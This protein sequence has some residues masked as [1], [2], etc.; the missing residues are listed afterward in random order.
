MKTLKSYRYHKNYQN[1]FLSIP[2]FLPQLR[3]PKNLT[4]Q[5][6]FCKTDKTHAELNE[7]SS[8]I[9]N[10][11]LEGH[12]PT[13]FQ[14]TDCLCFSLRRD[15]FLSFPRSFPNLDLLLL[16]FDICN[17]LNKPRQ[18]VVKKKKKGKEMVFNRNCME[19]Q[20]ISLGSR[21]HQ[22][23]PEDDSE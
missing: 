1:N 8:S 5:A 15:Y 12:V 17:T 21:S 6:N 9:H 16:R 18:R 3:L 2:F 7:S 14:A 19:A 20:I 23:C 13:E 22:R 4:D 11:T 10:P